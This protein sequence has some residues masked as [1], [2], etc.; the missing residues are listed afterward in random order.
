[1]Q[2]PKSVNVLGV[3]YKVKL[4]SR[5]IENDESLLGMTDFPN[6]TIWLRKGMDVQ[7][8]QQTLIHELVHAM[9]YEVGND[10][11]NSENLVN[12]LGNVMYQV[13]KD[14]DLKVK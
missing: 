1:M 3:K 11:Y 12:P 6:D 2:L 13:I 4:Q 5:L 14:N 7:R 10:D 9:L 8:T